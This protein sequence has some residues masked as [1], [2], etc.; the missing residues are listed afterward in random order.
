MLIVILEKNQRPQ[1]CKKIMDKFP[2][3]Q[4]ET[5]QCHAES[6]DN[7]HFVSNHT[8]LRGQFVEMVA[9]EAIWQISFCKLCYQIIDVIFLL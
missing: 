2:I 7:N 8:K 4:S 9:V 3:L 6:F 5:I 1:I